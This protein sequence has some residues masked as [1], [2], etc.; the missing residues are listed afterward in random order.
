L[1]KNANLNLVVSELILIH[2]EGAYILDDDLTI[3]SQT[4][5]RIEL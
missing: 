3:F 1:I 4:G 2:G 5:D